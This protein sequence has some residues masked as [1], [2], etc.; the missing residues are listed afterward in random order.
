MPRPILNQKNIL[1]NN[2]ILKVDPV[3][4]NNSIMTTGTETYA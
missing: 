3:Q 1:N 2:S 4:K